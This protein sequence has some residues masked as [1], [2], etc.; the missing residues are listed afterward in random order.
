M[1]RTNLP[2]TPAEI[3]TELIEENDLKEVVTLWGA[4]KRSVERR[5]RK[6]LKDIKKANKIRMDEIEALSKEYKKIE[7]A[8]DVKRD[9][10]YEQ[11]EEWK[12]KPF[13]KR[14]V[15]PTYP[16]MESILGKFI[17]RPS[18]WEANVVPVI[19]KPTVEGFLNWLERQYRKSKHH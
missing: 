1:A 9:K 13:W 16:K 7:T 15:P 10:W 8:N 2:D 14:G 12:N 17:N 19:E 5:N 11:M 4:Y 18:L 6:Q 3:I